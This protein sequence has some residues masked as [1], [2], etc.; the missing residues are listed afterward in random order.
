MSN[1]IPENIKKQLI[2]IIDNLAD[3]NEANRN[4]LIQYSVFEKD[5][6]NEWYLNCILSECQDEGIYDV[7]VEYSDKTSVEFDS[8]KYNYDNFIHTEFVDER[9]NSDEFK[10]Y[11]CDLFDK[12]I[13]RNFKGHCTTRGGFIGWNW[14]NL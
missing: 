10:I 14:F 12:F 11:A 8:R 9:G 6:D 3:E 2:K 1:S 5:D 13:P 7:N 4:F